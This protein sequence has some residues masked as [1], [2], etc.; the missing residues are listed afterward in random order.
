M[1]ANVPKKVIH[2]ACYVADYLKHNQHID[3]NGVFDT[4]VVDVNAYFGGTTIT[5]VL[6]FR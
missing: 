1:E 2:D 6:I 3:L 5:I 4:M